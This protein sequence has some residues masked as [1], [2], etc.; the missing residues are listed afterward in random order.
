MRSFNVKLLC[1]IGLLAGLAMIIGC[2]SGG[3][4][5]DEVGF[6]YSA[7]VVTVLDGDE[8][9]SNLDFQSDDCDGNISTIDDDTNVYTWTMEVS[10]TSQTSTAQ[11]RVNSF[12]VTLIPLDGLYLDDA[13]LDYTPM[14]PITLP[15][16]LGNLTY[17]YN[18]PLLLAAGSM[19][20]TMPILWSPQDKFYYLDLLEEAPPTGAGLSATE[21]L[22][23]ENSYTVRVVLHCSD[24]ENSDFDITLPDTTISLWDVWR[25]S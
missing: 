23:S 25:C 21:A 2:G 14:T 19:S 13:T 15:A 20:F 12:T 16:Q 10:V 1:C 18:T 7:S 3:D 24:S 5:L 4:L 9:T 6:R 8:E 11:L 22:N 17:Q